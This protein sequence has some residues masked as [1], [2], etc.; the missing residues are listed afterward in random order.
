VTIDGLR[1]EDSGEALRARLGYLP[2]NC[3][4]WPEMTVLEALFA[5]VIQEGGATHA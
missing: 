5:R 3:P 2:E 1:Q 4:L